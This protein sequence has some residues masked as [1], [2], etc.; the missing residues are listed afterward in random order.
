MGLIQIIDFAKGAFFPLFYEK[1][2]IV[3]IMK[4]KIM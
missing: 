1:E 2:L 4:N 3:L